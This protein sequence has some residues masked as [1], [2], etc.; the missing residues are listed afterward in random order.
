MRV[1]LVVPGG[2]DA[3]GEFR[4]IPALLALIARLA[5]AHDVQVIALAQE[6]KPREWQLAGATVHNIGVLH[7]RTRAVRTILALHRAARFDLLQSIWS[8]SCGLVA[9]GAARLLR[10]P[11]LVHVAGGELVALR[12]IGY[13]GMLTWRGRLRERLTLRAASAVSAA[14]TPAVQA[15]EALG[16]TAQRVPLGVDLKVWLPREPRRRDPRAAARLIHVASLN[17]VKD[18]G[19]LLR[20]VAEL[21]RAGVDVRMDIVGDDT[22]AGEVQS[23][24]RELGLSARVNFRGFLPQRVLRPLVE[25]ADLLVV[26]SRHETGPLVA[27]EAAAVGVPTVGTAVGHI[28][29]WAPRAAVAVPVG[30]HGALAGAIG[31][32][33]ADEQMRLA[34]A[35][36]ALQRA[37]LEDAD[38]TARCFQSIYAMVTQGGSQRR[39][40]DQ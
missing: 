8:G 30:D 15:I 5:R 27:L 13:G 39:R 26:S 16:V 29:E 21:V 35:H 9:V 18:Q 28:A 4:V 40:H 3:S 2:V 37:T 17:R 11:S 7:T 36:E 6:P 23:M 33:L 24:S 34:I 32:L 31:A 10:L 12:E 38:H 22:L 19:T 25:A 14:S 1:A 20:A